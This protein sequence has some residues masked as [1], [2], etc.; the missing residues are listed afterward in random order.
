MII[1]RASPSVP[2]R[3]RQGNP[4]SP[5]VLWL[6]PRKSRSSPESNSISDIGTD[7]ILGRRYGGF[8]VVCY[9]FIDNG[10]NDESI[11]WKK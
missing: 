8:L 3:T 6:K 5:M 4:V 7:T 11:I 10:E 1:E 9:L 2:F